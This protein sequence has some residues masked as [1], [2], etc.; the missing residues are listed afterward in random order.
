M[1][2]KELSTDEKEIV[3]KIVDNMIY[4]ENEKLIKLMRS[5]NIPDST[6]ML[7]MLGLGSHTA[8]YK[9][10]INRINNNKNIVTDD[11]IKLEVS[12]IFDEIDRSEE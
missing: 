1:K 3:S 9:V 7:T 6:I 10:L 4:D 12:K 5:F 2:K 8:Y 11:W